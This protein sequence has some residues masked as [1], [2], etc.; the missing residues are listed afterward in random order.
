MKQ[1]ITSMKPETEVVTDVDLLFLAVY[2]LLYDRMQQEPNKGIVFNKGKHNQAKATWSELMESAHMLEDF[3]IF[4]QMRNGS[5][6]CE[7]CRCWKPMS[8]ASPHMGFCSKQ[9]KP[10]IHKLHCC[11]SWEER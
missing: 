6:R 8:P 2:N 5:R 1:H 3:F 10:Y 11:K 4:R 9:K 7:L